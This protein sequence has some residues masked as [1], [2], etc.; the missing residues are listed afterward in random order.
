MNLS[1]CIPKKILWN[2]EGNIWS[3]NLDY[4]KVDFKCIPCVGTSHLA[5]SCHKWNFKDAHLKD[6]IKK[7]YPTW[8]IEMELHHPAIESEKLQDNPD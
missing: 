7:V 1:V 6:L 3:Q 8:L 4:E 2:V 5:I